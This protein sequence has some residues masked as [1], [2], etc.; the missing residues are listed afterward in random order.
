MSDVVSGK[1]VGA[2]LSPGVA[3]AI[4]GVA[5]WRDVGGWA[6]AGGSAREGQLFGRLRVAENL[7][8]LHEPGPWLVGEN[9]GHTVRRTGGHEICVRRPLMTL[10]AQVVHRPHPERSEFSRGRAAL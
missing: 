3:F 4:G 2:D 1:T 5:D 7:R 8:H 9:V 6:A 10:S